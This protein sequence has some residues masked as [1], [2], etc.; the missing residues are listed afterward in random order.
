[1]KSNL[2][3]WDLLW[4]YHSFSAYQ[5]NVISNLWYPI[6]SEP[7]R[8]RVINIA[9]EVMKREKEFVKGFCSGNIIG[10][11][12][13]DDFNLSIS[14]LLVNVEEIFNSYYK[15]GEEG[16]HIIQQELSIKNLYTYE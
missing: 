12:D 1:M 6:L 14:K 10:D 16:R 3:A 5:K 8:I 9:R 11:S 7:D 13:I 2:F 15:I 4:N